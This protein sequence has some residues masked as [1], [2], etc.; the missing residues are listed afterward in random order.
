MPRDS[1]T[2][3]QACEVAYREVPSNPR[4]ARRSLLVPGWRASST[5]GRDKCLPAGVRGEGGRPL[6]SS[7]MGHP[8]LMPLATPNRTWVNR[9]WVRSYS[10]GVDTPPRVYS[11]TSNW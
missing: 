2:P 8:I 10:S 1:L 3:D 7:F 6:G 9:T 11:S 4:L 5:C